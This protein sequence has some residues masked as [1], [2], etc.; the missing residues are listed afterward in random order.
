M[1]VLPLGIVKLFET[2]RVWIRVISVGALNGV[3]LGLLIAAVAWLWKGN[4]YVGL[5]VGAALATNTLVAVSIGGVVP[6]V[7]KRINL[8]PAVASGPIL[9]TITDM[10]GFFLVLTF[11]GAMLPLVATAKSL[12][13]PFKPDERMDSRSEDQPDLQVKG[14]V[15]R[16]IARGPVELGVVHV[17]RGEFGV[18]PWIRFEGMLVE[19]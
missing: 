3:A 2:M 7:L 4:P 9:T 1:R 6:L 10:C 11:A 14:V 18:E 5:V 15:V 16:C 8:D 12:R 17:L 19:R 13:R